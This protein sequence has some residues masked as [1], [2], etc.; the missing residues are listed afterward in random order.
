VLDFT[1]CSFVHCDS[2]CRKS[3]VNMASKRP[4]QM[5]NPET[6][7]KV[8]KNW[9]S[10]KLVKVIAY[11]SGISPCVTALP[12]QNSMFTRWQHHLRTQFSECILSLNNVWLSD[13]QIFVYIYV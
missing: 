13:K 11:Q 9:E 4:H 8:I 5:I 6:K 2:K 1:P 3:I 12:L 10:G 7:F